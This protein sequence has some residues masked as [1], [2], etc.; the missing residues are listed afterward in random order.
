MS[1]RALK[2]REETTQTKSPP[3]LQLL[4]LLLKGKSKLFCRNSKDITDA[5]LKEIG[6]QVKTL[7]GACSQTE[8]LMTSVQDAAS[9][10][11]NEE[12]L[13]KTADNEVKD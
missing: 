13:S 5:K 7:Q 9:N 6:E 4:L 1:E 12:F 2:M 11:S 10:L 3:H 8:S